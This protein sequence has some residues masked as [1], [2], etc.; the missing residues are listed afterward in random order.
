M[1]STSGVKYKIKKS[2]QPSNLVKISKKDETSN[3]KSSN[4]KTIKRKRNRINKKLQ[5]PIQGWSGPK[6]ESGGRFWPPFIGPFG[7]P[8]IGPFGPPFIGPFGQIWAPP[9]L[10]GWKKEKG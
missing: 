3:T 6:F 5:Q 7:P 9:R 4:V 8:F 1:P 10:G 2:T